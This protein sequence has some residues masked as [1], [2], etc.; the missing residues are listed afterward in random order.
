MVTVS[1][2]AVK[3][4]QRH[5]V[6]SVQ[7]NTL[8]LLRIGQINS[9]FSSHPTPPRLLEPS[10]KNSPLIMSLSYWQHQQIIGL[11]LFQKR[12]SFWISVPSRLWLWQSKMLSPDSEAIWG[13]SEV[14]SEVESPLRRVCPGIQMTSKRNPY[15]PACW[16]IQLLSPSRSTKSDLSLAFIFLHSRKSY[17]LTGL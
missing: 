17:P 9:P 1:S 11:S 6:R 4:D 10:F 12:A 16:P 3:A 7:R 13:R 2:L 5:G 15:L 14:R 8:I